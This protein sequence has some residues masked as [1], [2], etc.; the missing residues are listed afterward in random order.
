MNDTTKPTPAEGRAALQKIRNVVDEDG[1]GSSHERFEVPVDP[2]AGPDESVDLGA[3]YGLE[4]LDHLRVRRCRNALIASLVQAARDGVDG[5]HY[6]R[7]H[8]FYAK[9]RETLPPW[10]TRGN[11]DAAVESMEAFSDIIVSHRV[12]PQNPLSADFVRRRSSLSA[13]P[14]LIELDRSFIEPAP[15]KVFERIIVRDAKGDPKHVPADALVERT[16]AFFASGYDDLLQR[17]RFDIRSDTVQWL[18]PSMAK[19]MHSDQL[20]LVRLDKFKLVRIFNGTRTRGGRFYRGWWQQLPGSIRSTIFINGSPV[21]EHDFTACHFRLA[22]FALKANDATTLPPDPFTLPGLEPQM[23]KVVKLAVNILFNAR[24]YR[25][26]LGAIA[27]KFD[28]GDWDERVGIAADVIARIKVAYPGMAALWHSGCGGALQFIDSQIMLSCLEQLTARGIVALGVHDSIVVAVQ[29]RDVLIE[30]ME[31]TLATDGPALAR[32]HLKYYRDQ[33]GRKQTVEA[34]GVLSAALPTMT[35]SATGAH[36]RCHEVAP[37]HVVTPSSNE[38]PA[39]GLSNVASL[40]HNEAHTHGH[41][42]DVLTQWEKIGENQGDGETIEG[43]KQGEVRKTSILQ[44]PCAFRPPGESP[45]TVCADGGISTLSI[46]VLNFAR[47]PHNQFYVELMAIARARCRFTPGMLRAALL[48]RTNVCSVDQAATFVADWIT[49]TLPVT[50]ATYASG[51]FDAEVA[52]LKARRNPGAMA[53]SAAAKLCGV[54]RRDVARLGLT[55]LLPRRAGRVPPRIA[56]LKQ[57]LLDGKV[58]RIVDIESAAPWRSGSR[59]TWFKRITSQVERQCVALSAMTTG[60]N[61]TAL[62]AAHEQYR[63]TTA[64]R[65]LIKGQ[66]RLVADDLLDALAP[67]FASTAAVALMTSADGVSATIT[68]ESV[69]S[70]EQSPIRTVEASVAVMAEAAAT[71]ATLECGPAQSHLPAGPAEDV[72]VSVEPAKVAGGARGLLRRMFGS[73]AQ[74]EQ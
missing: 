59:S 10:W 45:G 32:R 47:G 5:V 27:A 71:T 70:I 36:E 18:S 41:C 22:Y 35:P 34:A 74:G 65:D 52:R 60:A 58:P 26:A 15:A 68:S 62:V 30:I 57:S 25:S 33:Y 51:D 67:I 66:Q 46:P 28:A 16:N 61:V 50:R 19:L 42:T 8:N 49:E 23:R 14:R 12:A 17:A 54:R 56:G 7:D 24:N 6:S 38:S 21:Y 55:L 31:R 40:S 1:S 63:A 13:G 53:W 69:T 29:H 43:K 3:T 48:D 20:R 2:F 64:A 39:L 44:F 4:P 37:C 9:N 72:G 11:V 73:N